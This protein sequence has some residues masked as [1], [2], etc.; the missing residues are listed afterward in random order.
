[1]RGGGLMDRLKGKTCLVTGAAQGIGRSVV[2]HFL[3]ESAK[4]IAA[5]LR[6][7]T[8]Q[9]VPNLTRVALDAVDET[10]VLSAAKT[11]QDVSVLVN[12]VGYVAHGALLDCSLAEFDRTMTINVRSMVLM[13]RSF[14]PAM[15]A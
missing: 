6:F 14:L 15:L 8:D 13:I 4:V 7:P 5:D 10:A 9:V 3:A 1:M 11:H 2:E 12:C